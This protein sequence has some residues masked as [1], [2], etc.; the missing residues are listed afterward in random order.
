MLLKYTTPSRYFI[1][2]KTLFYLC[3]H[4]LECFFSLG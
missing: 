3:F 1:I 2:L 4:C